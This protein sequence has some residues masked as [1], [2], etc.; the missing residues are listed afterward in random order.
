MI[1]RLGG[2]RNEVKPYDI[3]VIQLIGPYKR[4]DV[5]DIKRSFGCKEMETLSIDLISHDWAYQMIETQRLLH[6]E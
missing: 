5:F 4:S 1:H 6:I 3:L 2:P